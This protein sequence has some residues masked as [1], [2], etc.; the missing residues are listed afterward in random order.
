MLL[1]RANLGRRDAPG[2]FRDLQTGRVATAT[3]VILPRIPSKT[4]FG[5]MQVH[6]P[7]ERQPE[8]HPSRWLSTNSTMT[9]RE[10]QGLA[11]S[12]LAT[13]RVG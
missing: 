4:L 5:S 3:K 8:T 12:S 6:L 11:V 9:H 1:W 10:E 2:E 13:S 7:C